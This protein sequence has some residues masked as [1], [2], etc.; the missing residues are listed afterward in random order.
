MNNSLRLD[1]KGQTEFIATNRSPQP[2]K[3]MLECPQGL[4]AGSDVRV[5]I[6]SFHSLT[7]EWSFEGMA[8]EGGDGRVVLG[9][10]LP[11]SWTEKTQGGIGPAGGGLVGRPVGEVYLCTAQVTRDLVPGSRL[12]FSFGAVASTFAAVEGALSV[13]VREPVSTSFELVGEAIPLRNAAGDPVRLEAR[14]AADAEGKGRLVVFAT[15]E[16]LNPVADYRG[17]VELRVDGEVEGL[18]GAVEVGEEGR[19]VVDGIEL[20][21]QGLVRIE[22][23]HVTRDWTAK[24]GPLR[25]TAT[26]EKR[27]FFGD[28]HFHTRLSVDGDRDP[29]GAYTY[30]RDY[31]NLDVVA[32]ADHAPIGPGWEECLAVNEAFYEPGRFA[33]LPAWESSNAYGHANI[34]LRTPEVDGGPWYWNPDVC[35]SEVAWDED[36]VLVPHHPSAGQSFEKGKHREVLSKGIYWTQYDWSVA[37]ERARVVEI[38]QGRGNFE[39]DALDDY[40]GIRM[41]GKGASVQDALARGHR[42]GFVGGTDNHKGHSTQGE[43]SY[44]GMTCFRAAE[45]TREAIWQAM[46][47]RLTYATSGM[48][49]VCDFSVNGTD[50]GGEVAL[51]RDEAVHFAARL[52]G[53]APLEV[54]EVI[55]GGRCVWREEPGVWDVELEDI[56]LPAPEG[57][58]AYYYLR[59]RQEDGHRAWLSPVWLDRTEG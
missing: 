32:M 33:T 4:A 46:D 3:V 58:W 17:E 42:L 52:H 18:A 35:P 45:L 20:A 22:V 38:V 30:A 50:A 5:C 7:S 23:R 53:T 47:R 14:L 44:V 24:T 34:Y 6:S 11:S 49:I 21:G 29:S 8:V 43:G 10:G 12:V 16:L 48:P 41:G 56:E 51:G 36:V 9:H 31:L 19:G 27:H 59:L 28:I 55:S 39:A 2:L 57:A 15:D 26:G 13:K 25:R 1:C 40:W 54:V 37:N